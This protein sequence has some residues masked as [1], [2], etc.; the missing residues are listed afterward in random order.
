MLKSLIPPTVVCCNYKSSKICLETF[1][2]YPQTVKKR[3]QFPGHTL[4][5]LACMKQNAYPNVHQL[6]EKKRPQFPRYTLKSLVCMK[7]NLSPNVHKLCEKKRPQF[8]MVFTEVTGSLEPNEFFE[9]LLE[10]C[11]HYRFIRKVG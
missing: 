1:T 7:Q 10:K 5:S 8:P 11:P 2:N 3:P 4:K 9:I 6:C